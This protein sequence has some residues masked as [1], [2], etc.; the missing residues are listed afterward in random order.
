MLSDEEEALL[1]QALANNPDNPELTD[2]QLPQ[3]RP[4]KEVMP[5]LYAALMRGRGRPK[6]E[7]TKVPVKLRLDPE[8]VAAFKA[9]GAG[10]QTRMNDVLKGAARKLPKRAAGE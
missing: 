3:M 6:A 4:F 2:E 9:T 8:I 7:V 5:E 1:Q 10:W